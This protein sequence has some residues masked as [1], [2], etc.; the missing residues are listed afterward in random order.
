MDIAI[1]DGG[2]TMAITAVA[3]EQGADPVH[4]G[5]YRTSK[6]ES[7]MVLGVRKDKI[8]VEYADGRHGHL[9]WRDWERLHPSPSR[10]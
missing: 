8:F 5:I 7:L 10:C 6:N 4:G 9:S 2:L 1:N 3:F